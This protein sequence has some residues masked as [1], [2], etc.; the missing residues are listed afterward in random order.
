MH[1]GVTLPQTAMTHTSLLAESAYLLGCLIHSWSQRRTHDSLLAESAYLLGCLIHSCPQRRTH[2]LLLAESA[3]LL[4]CLIHSCAR[5]VMPYVW[6]ILKALVTKLRMASFG[7]MMPQATAITSPDGSKGP[8]HGEPCTA[9]LWARP[10]DQT[11]GMRH[12]EHW[13]QQ[14]RLAGACYTRVWHAAKPAWPAGWVLAGHMCVCP[15]ATCKLCMH[16]SSPTLTW[17]CSVCCPGGEA[18]VVQSVLAT[19]GELSRVAGP[20]LRPHVGEV[21]P[22]VILALQGR[23]TVAVATLGQVNLVGQQA[24]SKQEL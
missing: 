19:V 11:L 17:P 22:L 20:V 10:C 1:R 15:S 4:G 16:D 21:L 5:L 6:P 23:Y 8:L 12:A 24:K 7:V 9:Q 2:D 14:G 3:Y 18:G 13:Q